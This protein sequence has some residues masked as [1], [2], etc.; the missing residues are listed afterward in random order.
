M[1][2]AGMYREEQRGGAYC[3]QGGRSIYHC[4]GRRVPGMVY[5]P[6]LGPEEETHRLVINN[7]SEINDRSRPFYRA[8]N[9]SSEINDRSGLPC[10]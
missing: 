10:Y 8:I 2:T 4:A 5:T 3:R 9:N 1:Y 7:S 6:L